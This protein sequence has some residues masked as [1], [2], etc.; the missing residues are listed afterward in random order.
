LYPSA[1]LAS[2]YTLENHKAVTP[3][4]W[5]LNLYRIPH[6]KNRNSSPGKRPVIYMHHGISLSSASFALFNE[7]ESVAYILADAGGRVNS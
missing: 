3:D 7:N 2:G 6:G 5:V 1:L 4:G